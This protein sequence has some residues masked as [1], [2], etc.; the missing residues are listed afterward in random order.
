[1]KPKRPT[2][3]LA[4]V[5]VAC[6]ALAVTHAP[7]SLA[8]K[9]AS[10]A[11][12]PKMNPDVVK[13]LQAAVE[14]ANAGKF[15]EAEAE[16]QKA[17]AVT[18]KTAF[19]QFKIDE[20]YCFTSLKQARYDP[21]AKTCD[22]GLASGLLPPEQ[23]NDR[24]RL[25]SQLYLQTK[26]R[27]LTRSGEY[28]KRWLEATGNRDPVMLGLV[29]QAAYFSDNFSAAVTYMKEAIAVSVAAGKKPDENWL[30]IVQSSYAKLKNN[31]AILEATTEL[32]RYYPSKAQWQTLAQDLLAR[33]ANKDRQ[34]LQVYQLLS[35]V[36]A[37]DGADDFMEAATV[38]IQSGSPGEALKFMEKGYSSG[39]LEQSGDKAKSQALLAD[40]K[41]LSAA[42][43]KTL[44]QFEKE[45]QADK[46]GEADVKLGEAFLSYGQAAKGL[47]AIQRGITKGGVK[48]LDEANLSLGRAYIVNNNNPEALKT[49]ALVTSPEYLQ[50][51]RL[52]SIH[53]SQL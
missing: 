50:L 26:P 39:V 28:G 1:M 13:P 25:L 27:D 41:R 31:P 42:D 40:A 20:L 8:Q 46:A 4:A 14:F 45:A 49:F 11:K 51:A 6:F 35:Q 36:D 10:S 18:G 37:M 21:A 22:S 48:S 47:E 38:A 53:L 52:W 44:P 24:L 7:E 15:A 9:A 3:L 2:T 17:E 34:I 19:E 30:L 12:P 23:V 5:L 16:L 43:Q 33:S 32:L 29:G